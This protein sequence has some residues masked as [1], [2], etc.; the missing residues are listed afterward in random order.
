MA[1]RKKITAAIATYFRT[2]DGDGVGSGGPM[3]SPLAFFLGGSDVPSSP[4]ALLPNRFLN[5]EVFAA[6]IVRGRV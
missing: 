2:A 1:T 3:E 5:G 4:A 6:D